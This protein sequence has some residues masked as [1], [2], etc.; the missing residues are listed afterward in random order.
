[1]DSYQANQLNHYWLNHP[2]ATIT[3]TLKYAVAN[4]IISD[5]HNQ[6]EVDIL[7]QEYTQF[8]ARRFIKKDEPESWSK[9]YTEPIGANPFMEAFR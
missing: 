6:E 8:N 3:E 1:M 4:Q 5:L 2:S 7:L 9:P